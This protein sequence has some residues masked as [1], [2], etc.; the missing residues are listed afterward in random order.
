M[1][2]LNAT[3][4]DQD[5]RLETVTLTLTVD[6]VAV[7]YRFVGSVAPKAVSDATGDVR[8]GNALYDVA[9]CLSGAVLNRFFEGGADDVLARF[10]VK[11]GA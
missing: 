3:T 5:E 6:E 11:V 8:W 9:D 4:F 2:R 7:L 10:L 1:A